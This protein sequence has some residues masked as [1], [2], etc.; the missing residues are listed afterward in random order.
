M[1]FRMMWGPPPAKQR[2]LSKVICYNHI[3]ES[4]ADP[5]FDLLPVCD[6]EKV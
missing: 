3:Y 4:P 2:F 1:K 6:F 5:H